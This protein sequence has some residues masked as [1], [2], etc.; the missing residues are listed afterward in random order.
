MIN[1]IVISS[2]VTVGYKYNWLVVVVVVDVLWVNNKSWVCWLHP[3]ELYLI[4]SAE[5]MVCDRLHVVVVWFWLEEVVGLA[6]CGIF[7][8]SCR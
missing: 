7:N 4:V 1:T 2:T 8:S 6:N 3:A 5:V